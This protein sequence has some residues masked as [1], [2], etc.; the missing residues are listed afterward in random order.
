M[1]KPCRPEGRTFQAEGRKC[2]GPVVGTS[3]VVSKSKYQEVHYSQGETNKKTAYR[4]RKPDHTQVPA[5]DQLLGEP[6][7]MLLPPLWAC[8]HVHSSEHGFGVGR[9]S[10]VKGGYCSCTL[11]VTPAPGHMSTSSCLQKLYTHMQ[12]LPQHIHITKNKKLHTTSRLPP[13]RL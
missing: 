12:T 3:S 1:G 4:R 11:P 7:C 13:R 8:T 2:N 10:M 9:C 6:E 5:S